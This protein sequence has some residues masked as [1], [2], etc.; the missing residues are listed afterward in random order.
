M[1]F[2]I[3]WKISLTLTALG[4]ELSGRSSAYNSSLTSCSFMLLAARERPERRVGSGCSGEL[5][6]S[7]LKAQR[8]RPMRFALCDVDLK[9]LDN[10]CLFLMRR[11]IWTIAEPSLSTPSPASSS[12]SGSSFPASFKVC[13]QVDER[14][15]RLATVAELFTFLDRVTRGLES[16]WD[17][18]SLEELS[19]RYFVVLVLVGLL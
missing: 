1:C 19:E 16:D 5:E 6:E 18:A 10:W 3:D 9:A 2:G 13:L 7:V 8:M 17:S 12:T 14:I 15:P 11:F 4:A